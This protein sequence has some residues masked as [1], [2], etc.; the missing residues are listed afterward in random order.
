MPGF[1]TLKHPGSQPEFVNFVYEIDTM[2]ILCLWEYA[3]AED[4]DVSYT[5]LQSM[6]RP[7]SIALCRGR[8]VDDMIK[9]V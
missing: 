7:K 8:I 9:P 3:S 2:F 1:Y 4:R 5:K 6:A